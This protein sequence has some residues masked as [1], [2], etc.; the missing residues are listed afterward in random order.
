VS[1]KNQKPGPSSARAKVWTSLI[2]TTLGVV[3]S[4]V[5]ALVSW[6]YGFVG[7]QDSTAEVLRAPLAV[8]AAIGAVLI[9]VA[10]T[11]VL[12]QR[13]RG[14]SRVARLKSD[15]NDAY[16]RALDRSALNPNAGRAR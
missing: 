16:L 8:V 5:S 14:P 7:G 15:V 3:A 11:F 10:F 1:Q 12:A 4:L 9:S 13:E 2:T 6:L